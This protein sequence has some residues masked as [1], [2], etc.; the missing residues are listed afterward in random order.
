M[1]PL[2]LPLVAL[3]AAPSPVAPA[4]PPSSS[5]PS[6]PP[7]TREA[8]I[9]VEV[10]DGKGEPPRPGKKVSL[11]VAE[12]GVADRVLGVEPIGETRPWRLVVW[13]DRVL[14]SSRTL[15]AAAGALADQAPVLAA[16]GT[17]EVVV[18]EP[19]PRVVL[20]AT[21][22]A[23]AIYD[24][25]SR[26]LLTAEGRD[27]LRGLRQRFAD[28]PP[29]TPQPADEAVASEVRLVSR[30]QDA[31]LA[32]L[33][34]SREKGPGT[35]EDRPLGL[36]LVSDGF[37]RDPAVFYR[38]PGAVM[39]AK[40][41]GKSAAA[42]SGGGA[43][44][45]AAEE[46]AR[47]AAELGWTVLPMPVGDERLPE[48]HRWQLGGG[49]VKIKVGQQPRQPEPAPVL[50]VAPHEPLAA[51]AEATGG[52]LL[53]GPGTLAASVARLRS[54]YWLRYETAAATGARPLAVRAEEPGLT[55]KARRWQG[56]AAPEGLAAARA[57][58]LLAAEEGTGEE[59]GE[60]ALKA[61]AHDGV[62]ELQTG[63]PG[64]LRLT[65]ATPAEGGAATVSRRPLAAA[66]LTADGA[67]RV[68]LS[69][70]SGVDRIG[71]VVDDPASGASAG[72]L[73]PVL[74]A[75]AAAGPEEE[76]AGT[77]EAKDAAG[78][79]RGI[80]MS[81]PG[82]RIVRPSSGKGVGP[83]DVEVAVHLPA[84]RKLDRLELFWNDELLATLYGPP[85]RH[86]L[87]VPRAHPVGT[88]RAAARLDDGS[89][90]EDAVLLNGTTLGER[91]DVR[92]VE[93][94]VV[95]TD[96]AGKPVRG[97]GRDD[98][99]L[100]QDGREQK[101]ASFDDA[102]DFPVTVGLA[103]DTSAS[104]FI[105]LPGVVDAV[106]S[107]LTNGLA[108]R[109]ST[110]LVS[111]ETS[112]H[113]LTPPTRDLR[114][115]AAALDGLAADG[116]TNLFAAIEY[117]LEQLRT[118]DGRKALVV[119]S[120]GVG[121]G[122]HGYRAC[123]RA[124]R[125]SGIPVYLIVTN[126]ETARRVEEREWIGTYARRLEGLA[127]ATGARTFFVFPSQNLRTVYAE[128]LR[129]LRSQ[130]LVSYYPPRDTVFD[131]WRKVEVEVKKPGYKARTLSGYYARH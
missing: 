6:P 48:L 4:P 60:I 8:G 41:G 26:L 101:L 79:G 82:V 55:A 93:L 58:R 36:F 88:L 121:E 17:V 51:L 62:L 115:V 92:L 84:P 47:T 46:T 63:R 102:G 124:V 25:L 116:G 111:F 30:Q 11:A 13:I 95:V 70:P 119:Y 14:S 90:A 23:A 71:V 24:A 12:D 80:A 20:P 87:V 61:A 68:P 118:V 109:D 43:L 50:F 29:A 103:V 127:E 49:G 59:G 18:A 78:A 123:L 53:A 38:N 96:A 22:D 33:G 64:P 117:S 21:R 45:A 34:E 89:V 1:I 69:V 54:R 74:T 105:K 126:A 37:D 129:E 83:V 77:P 131:A 27:D 98:F 67:F 39:N 32:W 86:R 106:R 100:L 97:L 2:W 10:V 3:L 44:A 66:D 120:D 19:E 112:P 72:A 113:L 52:E 9:A 56:P 128:I 99:R 81:G 108:P 75:A 35:P 107:F 91:L 94:M 65:V 76:A 104:M 122:E 5:P 125:A 85:F 16:L 114:G 15:R 28:S 130:Y 40:P 31:L 42:G 110:L 73:V 57:R 7:A